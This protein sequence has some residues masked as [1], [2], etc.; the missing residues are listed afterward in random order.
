MAIRR[1]L[2]RLHLISVGILVAVFILFAFTGRAP[3][4]DLAR[5]LVVTVIVALGIAEWRTQGHRW[6]PTLS[7]TIPLGLWLLSPWFLDSPP[8]FGVLVY[9]VAFAIMF[10]MLVSTRAATWWYKV[11]LRRQYKS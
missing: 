2:S 11:V 9:W 10:A 8:V 6:A 7:W 4:F 1:R 3:L 5:L